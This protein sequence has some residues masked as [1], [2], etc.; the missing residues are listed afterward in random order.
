MEIQG[1][2]YTRPTGGHEHVIKRV[3]GLQIGE[4]PVDI[5]GSYE[6]SYTFAMDE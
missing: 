3:S 4:P 5:Q 6:I 2:L 1:L